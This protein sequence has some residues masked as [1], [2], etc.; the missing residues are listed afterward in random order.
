MAKT[1]VKPKPQG[2]S[3]V[4]DPKISKSHKTSMSKSMKNIE[5]TK[6][7]IT[8]DIA[9]DWLNANDHNRKLSDYNVKRLAETIRRDEWEENGETIKISKDAKV[10]DGQHRLAAIVV[11]N[12]AITTLVAWNVPDEYFDTI[13]IGRPRRMNDMLYI[14]GET[15]E[16]TLASA[17]TMLYRYK[18][19]GNFNQ[20]VASATP[21]PTELF[22]LLDKYPEIR[23][24]A[25]IG[26]K[27]RRRLRNAPASIMSV[28]H[29]TFS[30][31]DP[32]QTEI[33]FESLMSGANLS[34][35]DPIY[36]LRERVSVTGVKLDANEVAALTIKAWNAFRTKRKIQSISFRDSGPRAEA[37]PIPV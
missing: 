12:K 14:R 23:E 8:P 33:F 15:S 26:N 4:A 25:S 30:N 2:K 6:E 3:V 34:E 22:N 13:D 7:V 36:R 9:A 20:I 21:T 31:I 18:N 37:F 32:A 27:I 35:D 10:L 5:V 24:S 17:L 29:Y 28:L 19:R 11:A 16:R 1:R